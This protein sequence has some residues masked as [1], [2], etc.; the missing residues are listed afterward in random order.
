[1]LL[2]DKTNKFLNTHNGRDKLCRTL[3]FGSKF[4]VLIK[5]ISFLQK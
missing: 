3:Q 4:V 1:M 2:V 5:L